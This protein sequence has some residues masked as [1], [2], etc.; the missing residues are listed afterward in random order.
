[1][2]FAPCEFYQ[3]CIWAGVKLRRNRR[4]GGESF[5]EAF[6]ER[7]GSESFGT[8]NKWSE[9]DNMENKRDDLKYKF[10]CVEVND[11]RWARLGE[12]DKKKEKKKKKIESKGGRS[13]QIKGR[14]VEEENG[15]GRVVENCSRKTIS[16]EFRARGRTSRE[17][18]YG[19]DIRTFDGWSCSIELECTCMHAPRHSHGPTYIWAVKG[20]DHVVEK[21]QELRKLK[22]QRKSQRL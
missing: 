20:V 13:V 12:K 1:M 7:E 18:G 15:V 11:E 14:V 21:R 22:Q 16:R 3:Q 8:R 2:Y 17:G 5:Q 10:A 19:N 9:A 6:S 4:G